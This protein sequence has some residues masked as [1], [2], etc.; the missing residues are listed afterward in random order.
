MWLRPEKAIASKHSKIFRKTFKN[1]SKLKRERWPLEKGRK[2]FL[3]LRK[4]SSPRWWFFQDTSEF[5]FDPNTAI[6]FKMYL[7]SFS[8]IRIWN[9]TLKIVVERFFFSLSFEERKN[10][11]NRVWTLVINFSMENLREIQGKFS[12]REQ[13]LNVYFHTNLFPRFPAYRAVM[14]ACYN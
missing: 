10:F 9:F 6:L 11:P 4:I 12:Q 5:S 3:C 2:M 14:V 13:R 8:S 1:L 7:K